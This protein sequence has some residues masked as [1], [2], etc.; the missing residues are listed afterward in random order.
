MLSLLPLILITLP[1][2][3]QIILGFYSIYKT[4]FLKFSNISWI[5]FILQVIFSFAAFNI[6]DY[7]LRKQFEPYPV[8]CGTSLAGTAAACI[9]FLLILIL[10]I[11]IQYL[12][13]RW[14]AKRNKM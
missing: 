7:H 11:S 4:A 3:S 1:I 5:N 2:L 13:K 10:I 8:R 14:R 12:I 6:A 9:L